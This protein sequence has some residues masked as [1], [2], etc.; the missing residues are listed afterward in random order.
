MQ[1]KSPVF[2]YSASAV[3]VGIFCAMLILATLKWTA[4]HISISHDVVVYPVP[5]NS[6][7]YTAQGIDTN[8]EAVT[9]ENS[10]SFGNILPLVNSLTRQHSGSTI[11]ATKLPPITAAEY[12]V[13]TLGTVS[14]SSKTFVSG[15]SILNQKSADRSLPI[16]SLTKLVTAV[17]SQ[18]LLDPNTV[19]NIGPKVLSTYYGNTAKLSNGEQ[20]TA[21]EL[22]YPLLM[23]SSN[24]A[25]EA[26]ALA[27]GKNAFVKAM[28][29]WAYSVGAY[30]TYFADPTGLTPENISSAGDLFIM[31]NWIYKNRPDILAITLTKVKTVGLHDWVNPAHFLNLSSYVGGKDGYIPEAGLT[32]AALFDITVDGRRELVAVLVLDSS[33]RDSDVLG[34]LERAVNSDINSDINKDNV[35]HNSKINTVK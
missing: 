32:S 21:G 19:I 6:I 23:T 5:D 26:L 2:L 10:N 35:S 20:L 3:L 30:H 7:E 28:N 1:K 9:E 18:N 27:Y 17:V 4:E 22:L 16:A 8:A 12:L 31:L 29:D 33:N 13:E 14:S 24:D 34:L 15:N 25:A 11:S